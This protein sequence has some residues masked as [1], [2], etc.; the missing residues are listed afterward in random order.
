MDFKRELAMKGWLQ[1]DVDASLYGGAPGGGKAARWMTVDEARAM[2]DVLNDV[3]G[4]V[5]NFCAVKPWKPSGWWAKVG[6]N[7][8][9]FMPNSITLEDAKEAY[10]P[11]FAVQRWSEEQVRKYSELMLNPNP[12]RIWYDEADEIDPIKWERIEPFYPPR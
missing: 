9:V 6:G 4:T 2:F 3:R 5:D 10:G 7:P 1:Q 12:L 8:P 11:M